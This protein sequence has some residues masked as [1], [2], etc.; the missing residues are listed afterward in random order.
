MTRGAWISYVAVFGTL[1]G[2]SIGYGVWRES[3]LEPFTATIDLSRVKRHT[4]RVSGF[5]PSDYHFGLR[6][7]LPDGV[8]PDAFWSFDDQDTK[9]WGPNPPILDV[10]VVNAAGSTVLRERSAIAENEGW[11]FSGGIHGSLVEIYKF[12]EFRGRLL[13]SYT[14]S[15]TV[16][17]PSQTVRHGE[18]FLSVVKAYVLLPNALFTV[19]LIILMIVGL[20]IMALIAW[21]R[22]RQRA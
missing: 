6:V 18:V 5:F 7:K 1:I 3:T 17:R 12:R 9:I 20:P 4:F 16:V 15:V 19:G 14:V 2:L 10:E 22:R 8:T 11:T 21:G 13:G